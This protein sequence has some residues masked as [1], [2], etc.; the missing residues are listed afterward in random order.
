MDTS[1]KGL[2]DIIVA[3]LRDV[4]GYNQG[5]SNDYDKTFAMLPAN[6]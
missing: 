4:N 1:E 6:V 2:E 5:S 3:H